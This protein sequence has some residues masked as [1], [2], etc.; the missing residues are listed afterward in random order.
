[1]FWRWSYKTNTPSE[2]LINY[3]DNLISDSTGEINIGNLVLYKEGCHFIRREDNKIFGI[4]SGDESKPRSG[5]RYCFT[6]RIITENDK[7][8]IKCITRPS[9]FGIIASAVLPLGALAS[10][11]YYSDAFIP[12]IFFGLLTA[13]FNTIAAAKIKKELDFL[14]D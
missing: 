13:I 14:F 11:R 8:V 9:I 6:L 1:M 2:T 10:V 5:F 3:F 7:T 12:I 4:F